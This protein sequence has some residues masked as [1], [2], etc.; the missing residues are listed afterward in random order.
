MFNPLS[1]SADGDPRGDGAG[2]RPG[3]VACVYSDHC[4]SVQLQHV[5]TIWLLSPHSVRCLLVDCY[6]H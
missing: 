6:T 1:P 3:I 4:A 5:Q 2:C